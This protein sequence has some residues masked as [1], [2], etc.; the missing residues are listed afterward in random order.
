MR[1]ILFST[2]LVV[3]FVCIP[4]SHAGNEDWAVVD[5][6]QKRYESAQTFKARFFQKSYIKM[7]DQVQEAKGEVLIKKPGKMR[8]TYR[9]PDPQTLVSNNQTLWLYV[10]EDNQVT[11]TSVHNI[12]SSNTPALF[13][14]GQGKLKETFD[15]LS[16]TQDNDRIV[17]ELTPRKK[18]QGLARLVLYADK[19]NYQII[20]SS[21]Y[22]KLGNKTEMIFMS[23]QVNL[24]IPEEVFEFK[25]PDG[26]F[27]IDQSQTKENE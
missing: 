13:L 24:D 2:W 18:E 11:K 7:M 14:A 17:A 1:H 3:S 22:D 6:I 27:V 15:I 26:A 8:W 20:G 25:I 19:K 5:A 4:S 23:I 9:A 16:V 10:P 12:Y 21:V